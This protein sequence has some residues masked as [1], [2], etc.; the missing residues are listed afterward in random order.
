MKKINLWVKV[1]VDLD[2]LK[3]GINFQL[4]TSPQTKNIV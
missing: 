3:L 1:N 2:H 4:L